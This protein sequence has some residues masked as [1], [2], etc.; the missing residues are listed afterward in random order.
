M[1]NVIFD[2]SGVIKDAFIS[3]LWVVNRILKKYGI[4][5][6][7]FDELKREWE[8]PFMN[9]YN[10]YIPS[11][12][13]KEE[14]DLYREGILDKDYPQSNPYPGVVELIKELKD[15]GCYLAVITADMSDSIFFE[16]NK[17]GLVN[18]FDDIVTEAHDKTQSAQTLIDK[19]H[20][21]LANTFF[22]GDSGGEIVSGKKTGIKTIAVTWGFATEQT[23]KS[24]HPDYIVHNLEELRD[25]LR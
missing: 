4:K 10:K 13:L 18:V 14:Q 2:W 9:F 19:N 24:Y 8:E 20:L 7:S 11:M 5:E 16:I 17:F 1:K 22:I 6:M 12:T 3:H 25:V 23:L 21:D 15:S